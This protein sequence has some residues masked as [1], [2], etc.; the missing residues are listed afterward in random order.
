MP[1]LRISAAAVIDVRGR[2]VP[3][4]RGAFGLVMLPGG[5]Y[6]WALALTLFP[7]VAMEAAKALEFIRHRH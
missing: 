2:S 1:G 3:P 7:F 5:L 6:L 4:V